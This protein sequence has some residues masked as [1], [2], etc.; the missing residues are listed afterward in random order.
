MKSKLTVILIVSIAILIGFC[1][2]NSSIETS[3][4]KSAHSDKE[5]CQAM[6]QNCQS[7]NENAV[8]EWV[9]MDEN[10]RGTTKLL[11]SEK[12]DGWFIHGWGAC[13][14]IDCDWGEVPLLLVADKSH[15]KNYVRGFAIWKPGFKT[16]YMTL[17]IRDNHLFVEKV[18]VFKND[19]KR[20]NYFSSEAFQRKGYETN[21][22]E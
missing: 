7:F 20:S 8:G 3:Q 21:D 14:P 5:K 22:D 1:G 9:N 6:E 2:C 15:S 4:E 17:R 13:H 11:I 16:G 18:N 19:S 12:E 10:T